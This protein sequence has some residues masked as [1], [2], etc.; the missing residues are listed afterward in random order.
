MKTDILFHSPAELKSVTTK[1]AILLHHSGFIINT[2]VIFCFI[3]VYLLDFLHP[4]HSVLCKLPILNT[5]EDGSTINNSL[6]DFVLNTK[7]Y[8][9]SLYKYTPVLYCRL[10][11]NV[12]I[13]LFSHIHCK[14]NIPTLHNIWP[15]CQPLHKVL[16]RGIEMI[17]DVMHLSYRKFR[18]S[19]P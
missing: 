18:L 7:M 9:A 11:H 13:F 14:S 8:I 2:I 4:S 17:N 12:N 16:Y 3:N 15:T 5:F 10:L 1:H 19:S 6:L